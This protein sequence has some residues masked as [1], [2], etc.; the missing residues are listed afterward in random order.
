[1]LKVRYKRGC[2]LPPLEP[3][4]FFLL[5][6]SPLR[7]RSLE[8]S[9][10]LS[11]SLSLTRLLSKGGGPSGSRGCLVGS[12][13]AAAPSIFLS[14]HSSSSS[15]DS[16]SPLSSSCSFTAG[17]G[18]GGVGAR[19][20]SLGGERAARDSETAADWPERARAAR[21]CSALAQL[22]ERCL[23]ALTPR[24][25]ETTRSFAAVLK[26]G[27]CHAAASS[28]VK[29]SSPVQPRHQVSPVL[30]S[31]LRHLAQSINP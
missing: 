24:T 15:A 13:F 19:G 5:E 22:A 30:G 12:D 31:H 2:L 29:V 23:S 6:C 4:C 11:T 1:M 14:S 28:P 18:G 8:R 17:G 26:P 25:Q 20:R 16:L 21:D 3:L 27:V 10:C 9:L 7:E